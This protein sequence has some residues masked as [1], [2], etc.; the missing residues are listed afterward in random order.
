MTEF[1]LPTPAN[2]AGAAS[3]GMAPSAL[4]G[5]ILAMRPFSMYF[6]SLAR[7]RF[8]GTSSSAEQLQR[9][10]DA[11]PRLYLVCVTLDIVVVQVPLV[12]MAVAA[13][14]TGAYRVVMP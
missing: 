1:D 3:E 2:P 4:T 14:G 5:S 7:R 9:L 12:L 10:C 11:H 8:S 13:A 6:E